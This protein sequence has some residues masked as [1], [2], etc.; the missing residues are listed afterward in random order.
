[1]SRFLL[2]AGSL[3]RRVCGNDCMEREGL[4]LKRGG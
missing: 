4:E 2:S 3:A 1:V